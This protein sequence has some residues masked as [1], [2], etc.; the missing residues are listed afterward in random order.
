MKI[1]YII[2]REV[3]KFSEMR[4]KRIVKEETDKVVESKERPI[5]MKNLHHGTDENSKYIKQWE[6][7]KGHK[8]EGCS[9]CVCKND[10]KNPVLVGAHLIKEG[11]KVDKN[12]YIVPLCHKCNSDDYD[13]TILVKWDDLALY[14]EVKEE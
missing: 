8:A 3:K 2:T 10:E 6:S 4:I 1:F 5:K 11:D 13:G 14:K 9:N 12:W 7:L